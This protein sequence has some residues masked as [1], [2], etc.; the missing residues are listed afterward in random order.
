[1]Q[2]PAMALRWLPLLLVLAA[3]LPGAGSAQILRGEVLSIGDG[4]SPHRRG[5][6]LPSD[7]GPLARLR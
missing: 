4:P 2:T 1:M 3:V 7:L 5:G 6:L